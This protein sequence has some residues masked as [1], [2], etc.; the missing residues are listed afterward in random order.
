MFPIMPPCT[1]FCEF[2]PGRD[3]GGCGWC[4]LVA[5]GERHTLALIVREEVGEA[6]GRSVEVEV[7][8]LRLVRARLVGGLMLSLRALRALHWSFEAP[9]REAGAASNTQK[10]SI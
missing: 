2:L 6:V 9:A 8:S 10:P 7:E 3:W 1:D 5:C 4:R